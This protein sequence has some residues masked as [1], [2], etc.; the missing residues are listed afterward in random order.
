MIKSILESIGNTPLIELEPGI[1]AKCEYLN[2][3]GSIKARMA[4][5]MV[6]RAE[7]EGLLKPGYTI[8]ESTS[9]NTGN[10]LSMIA[11]VRGYKMVVVIPRGYSN[12]RTQI[13]RGFGAEVRFVGD[14]QVNE[15]RAEAIRLG[16]QDGWWCPRQFDNEWNVEENREWLAKEIIAQ[17]PKNLKI[18]ALVQGVGTAGT[19]IGLAQGLR[20]DHNPDLK[21]FAMEPSESETL[22][23]CIV[24]KHKIEG[25]SDGFIPTIYERHRAEVTDVISVDSN[26]A[27]AEAK[28]MAQTKGLFV[29][30]SSGANYWA[31]REIKKKYPEIKN[32]LTL[33]CD[34]GEKYLSMMQA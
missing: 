2:P 27:I 31:A 17:F 13:S 10:A 5:Y 26:V 6:E 4:L 9:G 24:C 29:G 32:I 8:V 30:P 7:K 23:C 12:E 20:R 1:L 3:S 18:D 11:A 15:A 28:N 34:T 33:L 21:A 19:L 16:Q 22:Q 14:F 25:I